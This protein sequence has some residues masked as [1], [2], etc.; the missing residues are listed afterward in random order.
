LNFESKS[1]VLA[2]GIF[3]LILISFIETTQPRAPIHTMK[4]MSEMKKYRIGIEMI[5]LVS[6]KKSAEASM[7]SMASFNDLNPRHTQH[8]KARARMEITIN[9]TIIHICV[10]S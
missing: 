2:W 4:K 7:T 1:N 3:G 10:F 9:P 5:L 8:E 6:H